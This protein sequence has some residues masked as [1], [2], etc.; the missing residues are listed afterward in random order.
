MIKKCDNCAW[1]SYELGIYKC[2]VCGN[3][4]Q[5]LNV[6]EEIQELKEI[7]DLIKD[8]IFDLRNEIDCRIEHGADSNGHLEYVRA[9]LDKLKCFIQIEKRKVN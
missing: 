4:M 3:A 7:A 2:P 6:R 1:V 5:K 8:K 9:E